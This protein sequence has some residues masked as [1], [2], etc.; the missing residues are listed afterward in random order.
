MEEIH[1]LDLPYEVLHLILSN[2]DS[3]LSKETEIMI[4]DNSRGLLPHRTKNMSHAYSSGYFRYETANGQEHVAFA[5]KYSDAFT[6]EEHTDD[7]DGFKAVT[8]DE[9]FR[10]FQSLTGW[11]DVRNPS[12]NAAEGD[13][14]TATQYSIPEFSSLLMPIASV[15]LIVGNRIRTKKNT[16]H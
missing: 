12:P 11:Y 10:Q 6:P 16:Q 13:Y 14:T 8:S 5:V 4:W 2:I 7:G 15:A 9:S 1:I 3:D